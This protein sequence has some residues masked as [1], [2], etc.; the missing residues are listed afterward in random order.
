LGSVTVT[1]EEKEEEEE[2]SWGGESR[3]GGVLN[4]RE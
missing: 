1:V 4:N 3:R 2:V